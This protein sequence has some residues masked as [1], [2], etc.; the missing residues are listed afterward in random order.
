MKQNSP[1]LHMGKSTYSRHWP[2]YRNPAGVLVD[3]EESRGVFAHEVLDFSIL[4]GIAVGRINLFHAF[5]NKTSLFDARGVMRQVEHR[6]V[7]ILVTNLHP[8]RQILNIGV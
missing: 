1:E 3:R 5:T 8:S 2:R 6:W 4:P 7:V